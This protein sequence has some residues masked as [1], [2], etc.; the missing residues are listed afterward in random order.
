MTE[1][2]VESKPDLVTEKVSKDIKWALFDVTNGNPESLDSAKATGDFGSVSLGTEA[3]TTVVT[4]K[5]AISTIELFGEGFKTLTIAKGH[6]TKYRLYIWLSND[7]NHNQVGLLNGSLSARV[8][9]SARTN[10][11]A[12]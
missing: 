6:S 7:P 12:S 5:K 3:G 8:G 9:F 11:S 2:F 4:G 10:S 1:N